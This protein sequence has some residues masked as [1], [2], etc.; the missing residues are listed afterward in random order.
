MC[1]YIQE[2][3][4]YHIQEVKSIMQEV[5]SYIQEV[6]RIMQEMHIQEVCICIKK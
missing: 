1:R 5:H 3:P 2:V 4:S 6:H